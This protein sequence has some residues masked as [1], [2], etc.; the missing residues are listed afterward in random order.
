MSKRKEELELASQSIQSEKMVA[1]G[2]LVAGMEHE[3][4]TP[5]GAIHS[6]NDTMSHAIARMRKLI[7]LAPDKELVRMLDILE[8]VCET[9]QAATGRIMTIVGSFRNFAR[10]D[11]AE[12]R[13]VNI[14]DGI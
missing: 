8:D 2:L 13:K 11:E 3:I 14:H 9:N 1:L 7:A 12:R 6:N 10:L 5:M 4:K